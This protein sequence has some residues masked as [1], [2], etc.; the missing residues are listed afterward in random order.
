MGAGLTTYTNGNR[1]CNSEVGAGRMGSL[2][3]GKVF[4]IVFFLIV[5]IV[6]FDRRF[7]FFPRVFPES[8]LAQEETLRHTSDVEFECARKGATCYVQETSKTINEHSGF[9]TFAQGQ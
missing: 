7:L 8:F 4:G 6:V 9:K 2:A 1:S 3:H 5:G